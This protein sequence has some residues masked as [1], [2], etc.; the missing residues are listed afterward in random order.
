MSSYLC[1]RLKVCAIKQLPNRLTL[2]SQEGLCTAD[3]F[4]LTASRHGT[5]QG[6][7]TDRIHLAWD[8]SE[9]SRKIT[10]RLPLHVLYRADEG[11]HDEHH[12]WQPDDGGVEGALA[13]P[14]V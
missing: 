4:I 1:M 2:P 7:Q 14:V 12:D 8:K 10:P 6:F 9:I 3:S 11:A 13:R 5:S